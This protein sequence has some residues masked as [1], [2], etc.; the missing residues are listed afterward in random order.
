[1]VLNQLGVEELLRSYPNL[2]VH[3]V[4]LELQREQYVQSKLMNLHLINLINDGLNV[5]HYF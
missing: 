2:R 4:M 1:M 3:H 5:T